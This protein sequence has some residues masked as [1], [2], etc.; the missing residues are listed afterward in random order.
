MSLER[1]RSQAGG[2]IPHHYGLILA[3]GGDP[4]SVR[5]KGNPYDRSGV[6]FQP[7]YFLTTGCI[8]YADGSIRARKSN[9]P[10]VARKG[11]RPG[12]R[13]LRLE[14]EQ[15]PATGGIPH[16]G[17]GRVLQTA[18]ENPPAVRGKGHRNCASHAAADGF[19][20][21]VSLPLPIVPF[22]TAIRR[23]SCFLQ[24]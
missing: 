7:E 15:F 6:T 20:G 9:A 24:Q 19:L 14:R 23:I 12:E 21:Q 22:K 13:A 2:R 1:E 17:R 4:L 11:R 10:A 8:K 3:G 16:L 5:R 18:A